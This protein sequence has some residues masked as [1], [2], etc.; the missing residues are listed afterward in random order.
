M[1]LLSVFVFTFFMRHSGRIDCN[2][3]NALYLFVVFASKLLVRHN[4]SEL[5][6]LGMFA[7]LPDQQSTLMSSF[8]TSSNFEAALKGLQSAN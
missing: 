1:L 4:T 2:Q 8:R 5:G 3:E 6:T 7:Y